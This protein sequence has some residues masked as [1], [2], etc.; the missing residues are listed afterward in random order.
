MATLFD[1]TDG[2]NIGTSEGEVRKQAAHRLLEA[3]RERLVLRARR[4]LLSRLLQDG[5]AT[6]DDVRAAVPVPVG[7][8]PKVFGSVPGPL[9]V[10]RIIRAAG[11]RKTTRAVGHARPVTEWLLLDAAAAVAWLRDHPD[12][13]DPP[14]VPAGVPA[15]LVPPL[16]SGS[17]CAAT[18]F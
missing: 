3:R 4:A 14:P 16:P 10:A 9:A 8:N 2:F 18:L 11:S 1:P 12:H 5:T 17:A 6:I 15:P 7:V 13:P